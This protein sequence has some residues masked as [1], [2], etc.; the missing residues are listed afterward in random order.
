MLE[1]Q[2]AW[3]D[4]LT[5]LSNCLSHP[6]AE[7]H[8]LLATDPGALSTVL[9]EAGVDVSDPPALGDRDL[10]ED[11]EA[12]FGAFVTPFAPPT[13]SPYKEWYGDRSGLMEGPP[14]TAMERRYAALDAEVPES[15]PA[16]H[17]SLELAYASLL[18][19]A[20]ERRELA[21]FVET[22]LD[23]ID[24]FATLVDEAAARAPLYRWCVTQLMAMLEVL[25][26]ELDL[27]GPSTDKVETMAGR[28]RTH[29]E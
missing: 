24:A 6:D 29:V 20:G 21:A 9:S 25:R 15:Y 8:E 12:L 13:A 7:V 22:E 19:E 14:A 3:A 5:A 28:A 18:A 27:A 26:T 4:A 2:T 11:Y 10:T 23:W 17:V 1:E 16:D